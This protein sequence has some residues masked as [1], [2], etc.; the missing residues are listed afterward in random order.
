[1]KL[2]DLLNETEL[3][4]IDK[5]L[6]VYHDTDVDQ[7]KRYFIGTYYKIKTIKTSLP[8][9]LK[10]SFTTDSFCYGL[11]DNDQLFGYLRIILIDNIAQVS[12]IHITKNYTTQNLGLSLFLIALKKFKAIVSDNVQTDDAQAFWQRLSKNP[13]L[14]VQVIRNSLEQIEYANIPIS[15]VW[16]NSDY[17]LICSFKKTDK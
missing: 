13:K 12:S 9:T 5:N 11:F 4:E 15:E 2:Y 10:L 6:K 1:M 14:N 16:W 8:Y 3:H 17:R 7:M